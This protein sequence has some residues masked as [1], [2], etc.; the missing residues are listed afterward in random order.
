MGLRERRDKPVQVL[1]RRDR[2]SSLPPVIT[3]VLGGRDMTLRTIRSL[4]WGLPWIIYDQCTRLGVL[5]FVRDMPD[6][7]V[8][9]PRRQS[10]V[11][12]A[13]NRGMERA[14]ARGAD[15]VLVVNNDIVFLPHAYEALNALADERPDAGILS[16]AELPADFEKFRSAAV[17]PVVRF[18]AFMM[19]RWV[20]EKIGSFDTRFY[21]AYWEDAD[22]LRRVKSAGVPTVLTVRASCFHAHFGSTRTLRGRIRRDFY[23]RLNGCRF[24]RKWPDVAPR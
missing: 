21:P 13:W 17:L 12:A 3:V 11:A 10:S 4:G 14:W 24:R 23:Y 9:R 6:V 7:E 19:R 18:S 8:L 1:S 2:A 16:M 5:D 15:R 22:Y 20:Y